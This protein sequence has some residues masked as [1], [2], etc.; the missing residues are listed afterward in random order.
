L[1]ET[2]YKAIVLGTSAG[3]LNALKTIIRKIKNKKI[4]PLIIVQHQHPHSD[5]FL[6]NYL[7]KYTPLSVKEAEEKENIISGTI[8]LSPAN[9]H[10]LIEENK[11]FSLSVDR[12]ENY[13]RPSIDILFDSAADVY[14][15]DLIGIILTGAN[16]DGAKGMK[17][18]KD[19]G[20]LT[21]IQNPSTAESDIMPKAVLSILN[22]DK[23]LT[24][25]QIGNFLNK[26][27]Q[28]K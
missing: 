4:P 19:N 22:V 2:N 26:L 3:G 13:S 25:E 18:I 12:P 21:I 15:P 7:A 23:I 5:N 10:L 11:T 28:K 27:N 17:T 9:Y 6:V 20:G 1:S 16:T 8:Y 14:C 24:L